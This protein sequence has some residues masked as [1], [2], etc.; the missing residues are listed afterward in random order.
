MKCALNCVNATMLPENESKENVNQIT[1]IVLLGLCQEIEIC[2]LFQ[3][4]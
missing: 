1:H 3:Q 2:Q 4:R